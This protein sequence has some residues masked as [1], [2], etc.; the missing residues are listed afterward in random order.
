MYINECYSQ[1]EYNK[2]QVRR[3]CVGDKKEKDRFT[4][5]ITIQYKKQGNELTSICCRLFD[6]SFRKK[7]S[8]NKNKTIS[9]CTWT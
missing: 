6:I 9:N 4:Q 5:F 2:T 7:T 3:S 8:K 1:K